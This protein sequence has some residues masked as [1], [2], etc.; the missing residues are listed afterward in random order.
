MSLTCVIH[1][2]LNFIVHWFCSWW[3]FCIFIIII[4]QT[5]WR[6]QFLLKRL[7][8]EFAFL[9]LECVI[10]DAKDKRIFSQFK[11]WCESMIFIVRD[12]EEHISKY[13]RINVNISCDDM[14]WPG[15]F[16]GCTDCKLRKQSTLLNTQILKVPWPQLR[17][18]GVPNDVSLFFFCLRRH[19]LKF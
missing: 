10:I 8:F 3:Q 6:Y 14:D 7:Q 16:L 15:A 1:L 2:L 5:C 17:Q 13:I 18:H 4:K 11:D 19:C 12:E 9:N